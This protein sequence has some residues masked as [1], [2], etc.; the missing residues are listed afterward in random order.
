MK[1]NENRQN[2]RSQKRLKII[3]GCVGITLSILLLG[4]FGVSQYYK[5]HF[6]SQ[7][8]IN[9]VDCSNLTVEQAKKRINEEVDTYVLKVDE[10]NDVT[11]EIS[12][13]QIGLKLVFDKNF[14]ELL[15]TQSPFMWV[16]NSWSKKEIENPVQLIYDESLLQKAYDELFAFDE[17]YITKPVDAY[18]TEYTE[19]VGFSIVPEVEGNEVM[20]DELFVQV[21]EAV[22]NLTPSISVDSLNCYKEPTVRS[23]DAKLVN[24]IEVTNKYMETKL[25]YHFGDKTEVL[26]GTIIGPAIKINE[27]FEVSIDKDKIKEFVD[28]IGKTYNTFGKTRTFMSSYGVEATVKNG[29]Y[30]WWLDRE[31]EQSEIIACIE[32]GEQKDKDPVYFQKAASYDEQDYGDTYVEINLSAQHL[33]YYKDGKLIV[34]SD[35]V[36]G[37]VS[38]NFA[39]PTG[40]YS[41]TYT[42][43]D[44]ELKGEGYNTKVKYW[45][46][47]NRNI[48]MHDASWRKGRFGGNIFLTNGSHGCINLPPENAKKIFENIEKG[49]AVIVYELA[50]TESFNLQEQQN[51]LEKAAA[52]AKKQEENEE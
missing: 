13:Q 5:S 8:F 48:G 40:T 27:K 38:R 19:G 6:Y 26:D 28:Y 30:G 39:T 37:N 35:F 22:L 9:G 20:K 43:E 50:G 7:T 47:F 41:V 2:M 45:M 29:D 14:E 12:G 4:Y 11:E 17:R 44:A 46:P 3:I 42:K 10:R 51:A 15:D 49:T 36:S 33:F 31:S 32:N 18:I 21:K 24:A 16:A 52:I 23:D 34:E 1:K 25:T